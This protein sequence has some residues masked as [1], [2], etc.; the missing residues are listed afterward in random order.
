MTVGR[1]TPGHRNGIHSLAAGHAYAANSRPMGGKPTFD[2][3]SSTAPER[4]IRADHI[5]G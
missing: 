3:T 5:V 4:A 1:G 2:R